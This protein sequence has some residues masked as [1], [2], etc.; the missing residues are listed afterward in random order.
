MD[1]IPLNDAPPHVQRAVSRA[2]SVVH[3]D[4]RKRCEAGAATVIGGDPSG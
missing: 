4:D 3:A 2:V 1:R